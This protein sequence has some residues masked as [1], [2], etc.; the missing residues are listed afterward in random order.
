MKLFNA[1]DIAN[2]CGLTEL[3]EAYF[4]IDLH[5]GQIFPYDKINE[6]MKELRDELKKYSFLRKVEDK[7]EIKPISLAAA[8]DVMNCHDGTNLKFE[9][10][11]G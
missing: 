10:Y 11:D 1:M 3:S 2:A 9:D 6:E 4:N 8:L 5:C 7:W